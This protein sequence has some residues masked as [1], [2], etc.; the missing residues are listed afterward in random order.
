MI[1]QKLPKNLH[2]Q[3]NIRFSENPWNNRNSKFLTQKN[4]PRLCMCENIREPPPGRQFA[5]LWHQISLSLQSLT[6]SVTPLK[7]KAAVKSQQSRDPRARLGPVPIP[8]SCPVV[9]DDVQ[10]KL[11]IS[12]LKSLD[13]IHDAFRKNPLLEIIFSNDTSVFIPEYCVS[14]NPIRHEQPRILPRYH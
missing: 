6:K 8:V 10:F 14:D 13:I 1:P 12:N 9:S 7:R 3:K 5:K 11:Q 4:Y 2:T